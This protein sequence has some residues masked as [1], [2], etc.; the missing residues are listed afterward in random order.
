MCCNDKKLEGF[1]TQPP[2]HAETYR[3]CGAL[4]RFAGEAWVDFGPEQK[5]V[6]CTL[7][8]T[9]VHGPPSTPTRIRAPR[10]RSPAPRTAKTAFAVTSR[11]RRAVSP[12][13]P[14]TGAPPTSPSTVTIKPNETKTDTQTYTQTL[15]VVVHRLPQRARSRLQ[16]RSRRAPAV[17]RPQPPRQQAQRAPRLVR[18]RR[19]S[20]HRHH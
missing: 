4:P 7:P 17:P 19:A 15:L 6:P 9:R 5:P 1:G 2:T 3:G 14:W 16:D 20:C 13:Q 8:L 18:R 10:D 11:R 12:P